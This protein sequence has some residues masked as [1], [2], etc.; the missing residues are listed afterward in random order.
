[1]IPRAL[2]WAIISR[3]FRAQDT[4]FRAPDKFRNPEIMY[5]FSALKGRLIIAQGNALG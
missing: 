3:P 5:R 2:P 4:T 1:L